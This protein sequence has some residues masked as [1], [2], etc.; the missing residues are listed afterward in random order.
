VAISQKH[1]SKI[2]RFNYSVVLIIGLFGFPNGFDSHSVNKNC[3]A[4]SNHIVPSS[5]GNIKMANF[6]AT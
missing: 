3:N 5:E 6:A 2:Q 1:V 4:C